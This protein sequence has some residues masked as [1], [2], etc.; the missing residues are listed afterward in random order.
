MRRAIRERVLRDAIVGAEASSGDDVITF[1]SSL[2]SSGAQQINLTS[3]IT[4]GD[5]TSPTQGNISIQGPGSDLLSI[6]ANG[7]GL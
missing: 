2:F 3:G 1:D 7:R 5:S 4:I 6:N